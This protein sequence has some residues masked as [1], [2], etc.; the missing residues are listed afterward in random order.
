[1]IGHP[2][3]RIAKHFQGPAD[4]L[5][6]R[7]VFGRAECPSSEDLDVLWSLCPMEALAEGVKVCTDV[8]LKLRVPVSLTK[9][10]I[11][12]CLHVAFLHQ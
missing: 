6:L 7:A 3:S 9:G 2:D 5:L 1:M 4:S 8:M 12:E 10:I 11:F